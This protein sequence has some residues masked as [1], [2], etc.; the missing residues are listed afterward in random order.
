MFDVL[1]LMIFPFPTTKL[2]LKKE[3]SKR[4]G[5]VVRFTM[6]FSAIY[7]AYAKTQYESR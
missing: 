6:G 5:F 4:F 1:C 3:K 2:H 7:L